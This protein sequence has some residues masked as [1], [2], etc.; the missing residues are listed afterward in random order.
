VKKRNYRKEY[1]NYQGTE[2]QKKNRA[3][4]NAARREMEKA[5]KVSKGDGKD[6]AHKKPLAKG[7]SN[8]KSNLTVSSKSKNRS[9]KRTKKAKMA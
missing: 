1:D 4:R 9:F 5:G 8:K 3:K 7:G 6:V 2:Q